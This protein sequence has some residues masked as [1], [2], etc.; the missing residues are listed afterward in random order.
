MNDRMRV[1]NPAGPLSG[2]VGAGFDDGGEGVVGG[3]ELGG[4]H[5][6]VEEEGGGE[7]AGLGGGSDD[8]LEKEG[9]RDRDGGEERA[10]VGDGGGGDGEGEELGEE[11]EGTEGE[12]GDDEVGV[13]LLKGA[14]AGAGAEEGLVG[15]GVR[16]RVGDGH[17]I[18]VNQHKSSN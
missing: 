1:D 10:G 14:E 11:R 4:A 18:F 17:L 8:G 5:A 2:D 15:W 13:D 9:V 6:R 3:R 16:T 12:A 7:E